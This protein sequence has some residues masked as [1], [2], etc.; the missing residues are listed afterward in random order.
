MAVFA[1]RSPWWRRRECR[2]SGHRSSELHVARAA[3]LVA[4]CRDLPRLI[5]GGNQP[6]READIILGEE[7]HSE[8]AIDRWVSINDG[9]HVVDRLDDELGQV[10]RWR[11]FAG[12]E[13]GAWKVSPLR[14]KLIIQD[15]LG[16]GYRS[17]VKNGLCQS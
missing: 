7:K 13:K 8:P 6:L 14:L 11:R 15:F 9:S 1:H 3:G 17:S 12:E 4:S 16:K 10:V 5:A 2:R